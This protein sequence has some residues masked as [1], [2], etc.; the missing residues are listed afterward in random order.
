MKQ[1]YILLYTVNSN[2]SYRI[3]YLE[4]WFGSDTDILVDNFQ[5]WIFQV[6]E[7]KKLGMFVTLVQF[8]FYSMFGT[9]ERQFQSNTTR[10]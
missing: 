1:C 10:K 4:Y 6:E 9:I 8:G 3:E 5:E 2:N 7:M